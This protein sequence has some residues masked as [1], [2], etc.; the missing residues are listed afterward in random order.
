MIQST[1]GCKRSDNSLLA[2]SR[3]F[4]HLSK[5]ALVVN[6]YTPETLAS[7]T[8]EVL[9]RSDLQAR[10]GALGSPERDRTRLRGYVG[11]PINLF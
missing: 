11:L 2:W 7:R 9:E 8:P 10:Q 6:P 3:S 4:G 5:I 1:R